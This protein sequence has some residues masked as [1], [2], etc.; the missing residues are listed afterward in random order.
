M[1]QSPLAFLRHPEQW[2]VFKHN[3]AGL[4]KW[5]TEECLRYDSP[6]KSIQRIAAQDVELR[7]K[8]LR[9]DDRLRWFIA[10]AN[11]DP[12]VFA[13][14]ETFDITRDP[15][16]AC[17][18]W[19]W[20]ASLPGGDPG[21]A[22][23]SGGLQSPGRVFPHLAGRDGGVSVLA[24]Y[25][26]S[27]AQVPHAIADN[28]LLGR[29]LPARIATY[30]PEL[31]NK[32]WPGIWNPAWDKRAAELYG[33]NPPKAKELLAQAGYPQGFTFTMYLF[34]LPGLPEQVDIGQ[35]MALDWQAIGP[36]PKLVEIDFPRVRELYRTKAIHGAVWGLRG[37]A[38]PPDAIRIIN[39]SY[40]GVIHAYEHP[41]I[42]DSLH[43]L[44][45]VLAPAQ[46]ANI[47]RELGDHKFNE[48]AGMAL[49]WL[50]AEAAVNP[51]VIAEYVFP[52]RIP[53]FYTHLAYVKLAP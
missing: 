6:V 41:F 38:L 25:D 35:A 19:F 42:D 18:V 10:S 46:R 8:V 48:F 47:L 53:G 21:A 12:E 23:G 22:G 13:H 40:E 39:R 7:G 30:H 9:Q 34:P 2:E 15:N 29:A 20:G 45:K 3:P 43:E 5:A 44:G 26:I 17:G 37:R 14:H 24:Q 52:G 36:Q 1:R 50:F 33:Y 49:F 11:R 16:P 4:A 27:F 31:D 32:L 51:R 28:L